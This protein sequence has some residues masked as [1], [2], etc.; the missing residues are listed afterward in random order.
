MCTLSNWFSVEPSNSNVLLETA[1]FCGC[2]GLGS[3]LLTALQV[4]G[5]LGYK[6]PRTVATS[7]PF[8]LPCREKGQDNKLTYHLY[9]QACLEMGST[10]MPYL[11]LGFTNIPFENGGLLCCSNYIAKSVVLLAATN[12]HR[13]SRKV[14]TPITNLYSFVGFEEVAPQ[15]LPG[16]QAEDN[17][18]VTCHYCLEC[19]WPIGSCRF[20]LCIDTSPEDRANSKIHQCGLLATT[21]VQTRSCIASLQV[22]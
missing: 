11:Q 8:H 4:L 15:C 3:F 9:F 12:N 7:E 10:Y 6:S 13:V 18:H 2:S 16:R 1:S 14:T 17:H 19:V 20:F 22:S 5:A 21:E